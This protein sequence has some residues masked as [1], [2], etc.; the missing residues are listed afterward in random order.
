MTQR[1]L[2][3]DSFLDLLQ[4]T[5]T[6]AYMYNRENMEQ[7]SQTEAVA[8]GSMLGV[9]PTAF[10]L[11]ATAATRSELAGSRQST[12]DVIPPAVHTS[13]HEYRQQS[14]T[15][16]DITSQITG[17]TFSEN[18]SGSRNLIRG[19]PIANIQQNS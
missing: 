7:P 1:S 10:P 6:T 5:A 12:V 14:Q 9:K 18:R 8:R 13:C 19:L 2:V 4:D 17:T 11:S 3:N 15:D 16:A